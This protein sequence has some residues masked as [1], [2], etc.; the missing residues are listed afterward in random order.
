MNIKTLSFNLTGKFILKIHQACWRLLSSL[1]SRSRPWTWSLP[2]GTPPTP[3]CSV[4]R[5]WNC[6]HSVQILPWCSKTLHNLFSPPQRL[7]SPWTSPGTPPWMWWPAVGTLWQTF[8]LW[9][10]MVELSYKTDQLQICREIFKLWDTTHYKNRPSLR[11]RN[12]L[13]EPGSLTYWRSFRIIDLTGVSF[14]ITAKKY[15]NVFRKSNCNFF[16]F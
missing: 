11:T 15:F 16:C 8:W 6:L 7:G 1:S 13:Y 10:L 3:A 9:W 2:R 4:T 12:W 5:T 14:I